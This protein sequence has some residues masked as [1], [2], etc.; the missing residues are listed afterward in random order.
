MKVE[1]KM[2]WSNILRNI[3]LMKRGKLTSEDKYRVLDRLKKKWK[4]NFD[5][6]KVGGENP[7]P[8][9]TRR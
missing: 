4:K 2:V 8:L 1:I 5:K 7:T 6:I 3:A 9:K